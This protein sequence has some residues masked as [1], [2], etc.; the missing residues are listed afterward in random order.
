MKKLFLS[1]IAVVLANSAYAIPNTFSEGD[2]VSAEKMNENFQAL[3]QQFQ[4]SRA[5]TVNC[6]ANEKIGKAIDDG[7]T[8]ITVSGTCTENLLFFEEWGDST[9]D[10]APRY[11][12]LTGADST[13][14]IVDASGGSENTIFVG[15]GTTLSIENLTISGGTYGVAAYRNS[16]LLL[17]G[18]TIEKLQFLV[19]QTPT[20]EFTLTWEPMPGCTQL[21]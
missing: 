11:L 18:V 4:G 21:T 6:A 15:A 20:M 12:K 5:T 3:E 16:N 8:N 10:L 19:A 7:Y 9:F 1:A 13:A 17:S 2:I 14:K